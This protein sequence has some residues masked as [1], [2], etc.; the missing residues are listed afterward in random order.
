[1]TRERGADLGATFKETICK[2]ANGDCP[3]K[4]NFLCLFLVIFLLEYET[5]HRNSLLRVVQSN[6]HLLQGQE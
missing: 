2:R 1:M 4:W 6:H 3:E 5:I